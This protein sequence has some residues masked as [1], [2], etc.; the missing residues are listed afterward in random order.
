MNDKER[1]VDETI[2]TDVTALDKPEVMKKFRQHLS[3]GKAP[4]ARERVEA[5]FRNPKRPQEGT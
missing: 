2:D 1:K 5:L 4:T 3:D